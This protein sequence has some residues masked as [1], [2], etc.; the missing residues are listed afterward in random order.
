MGDKGCCV[1][2][3]PHIYWVFHVLHNALGAGCRG[4]KSLR[5][6]QFQPMPREV[7]RHGAH[8]FWSCGVLFWTWGVCRL[9]MGRFHFVMGRFPLRHGAPPFCRL[10][11]CGTR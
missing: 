8:A 2:E 5:P 4:F 7:F 6:D 11:T 1:D 3:T 9:D 10:S